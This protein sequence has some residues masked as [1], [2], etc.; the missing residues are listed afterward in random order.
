MTTPQDFETR[1]VET[2]KQVL[3]QLCSCLDLMGGISS[4]GV[5]DN[6]MFY[7]AKQMKE[8]AEGYLFLREHGGIQCTKLLVRPMIEL[9]VRV[10][11]VQ[12]TPPL[13]YQIIF[14]EWSRY[15]TWI[16]LTCERQSV[17]YDSARHDAE[18]QKFKKHCEEQFSNTKLEEKKIPIEQ[19][20]LAAQLHGYYDSHYRLYSTFTHGTLLAV[21][22]ILDEISKKEDNIAVS[23]CVFAIIEALDSRGVK[24]QKME[25]LRIRLGEDRDLL[26]GAEMRRP[27]QGQPNRHASDRQVDARLAQGN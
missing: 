4:R 8:S 9:M 1:T 13:L 23:L 16:R 6:F 22:G 19:V 26:S 18:W 17:A 11:A 20:A 27:I 5:L 14:T 2:I 10:K 7:S 21:M 12:A 24:A 3:E 25:A 15:C